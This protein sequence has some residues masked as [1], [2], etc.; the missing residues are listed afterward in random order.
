[1]K[2]SLTAA[3]RSIMQG[4]E[5]GRQIKQ[6]FHD[7][8]EAMQNGDRAR[9]IT[10]LENGKFAYDH[11]RYILSDILQQDDTDV[12]A[13]AFRKFAGRNPNYIVSCHDSTGPDSPLYYE[14][15]PLLNYAMMQ[16]AAKIALSLAQNPQTNVAATGKTT[17]HAYVGGGFLSSGQTVKTEIPHISALDLARERGMKEVE[18]AVRERLADL[19]AAEAIEMKAQAARM[20]L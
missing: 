13:V 20:V 8:R 1:M 3:Y 17:K 11:A 4:I 5:E 16:G 7:F 14:T 19:K 9:A 12:F 2:F 6:N 15:I 18:H 10:V